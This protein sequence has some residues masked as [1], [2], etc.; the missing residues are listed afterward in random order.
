MW[1][2]LTCTRQF[3]TVNQSHSC[4]SQDL[5]RLFE[6]RPDHLVLAFDTLMTAVLD[7]QPQTVGASK[8]AIVFTNKKAW[9]IVKPLRAEL[10]VKFYSDEILDSPLVKKITLWNKKQGH[11]VRLRDEREVTPALLTLLRRGYDFALR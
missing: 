4:V 10:D 5:G 7:W 8:N 11:H 2:C 6:G 3:K 1:T 9:L